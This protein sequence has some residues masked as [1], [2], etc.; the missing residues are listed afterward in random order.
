MAASHLVSSIPARALTGLDPVSLR[1]LDGD[2]AGVDQSVGSGQASR[3]PRSAAG[4]RKQAEVERCADTRESAHRSGQLLV[5]GSAV[6]ERS[7]SARMPAAVL[8]TGTW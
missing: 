7:A 5:A 8:E 4:R 3:T 2:H 6:D 1:H